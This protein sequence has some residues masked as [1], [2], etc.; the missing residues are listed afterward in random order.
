MAQVV[1]SIEIP[2][3]RERPEGHPGTGLA[4]RLDGGR[5]LCPGPLIPTAADPDLLLGYSWPGNVRLAAVIERAAILGKG[6]RLE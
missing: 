4:L 6:E 2:P 1:F 5:R 3:L